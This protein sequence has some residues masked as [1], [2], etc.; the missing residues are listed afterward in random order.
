MHNTII[1]IQTHLLTATKNAT[2]L[3]PQYI[4]KMIQ[5]MEGDYVKQPLHN[6]LKTCNFLFYTDETTGITSTEQ[7]AVYATFCFNNV[8]SERFIGLNQISKTVGSLLS[9]CQ[10]QIS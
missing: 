6:M 7:F 4:P 5:V 9:A 2:Y 10:L 8:V 3:S 1:L